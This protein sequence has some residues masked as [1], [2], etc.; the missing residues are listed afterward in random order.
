MDRPQD[1]AAQLATVDGAIVGVDVERST[2]PRWDNPAALVQVGVAERAVL[3]DTHLLGAVPLL[4]EFLRERVVVLHAATNDIASMDGAAIELD[5]LEDTSVAAG[6]LGL[7]LGLDDLLGERLGVSLSPDKQRFQRADWERRPLPEDMADYAAGDVVHLPELITDLR[8]MLTER[9]RLDWY[10]QERDHMIDAT[11]SNVRHWE[12]TKGGG[13]LSPEQRAVLRALWECREALAERE[14]LAP[15]RV[16]RD[17]T[18]LDLATDP[19]SDARGLARRNKRRGAPSDAL[20]SELFAAQEEGR[21]AE[22]VPREGS[23]R[24]FDATDRDRH[25][26]M[27]HARSERAD[28]LGMSAGLLCPGRVLWGGIAADPTGPDELVEAMDLRR[29]QRDQLRE[30]LWDAY[31]SVQP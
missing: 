26:A 16:L 2:K 24:H 4:G 20:A 12:D 7:P 10:R 31:T 1:L 30:A 9:D 23:G 28:E 15:Q 11:R 14:D 25:A 6:L 21:R 13:R 19:A 18:L 22:P 5:T 3:V 27:R 17:A 29:W 8:A